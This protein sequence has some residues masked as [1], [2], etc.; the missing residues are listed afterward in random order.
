MITRRERRAALRTIKK[1]L[2]NIFSRYSKLHNWV[3]TLSVSKVDE[4]T[5]GRCRERETV[6][7][8]ADYITT[9]REIVYLLRER[10]KL[11]GIVDMPPEVKND[12]ETYK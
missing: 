5:H 9:R 4:I 3:K 6:K 1:R 7:K 8:Y 2:L 10:N 11:E 12:R